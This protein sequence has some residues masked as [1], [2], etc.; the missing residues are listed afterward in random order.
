MNA[1]VKNTSPSD[2]LATMQGI[3]S[4]IENHTTRNAYSKA[5]EVKR[6][7]RATIERHRAAE[8]ESSEENHKPH[9]Q[10]RREL[11]RLEQVERWI[12][13]VEAEIPPVDW[14]GGSIVSVHEGLKIIIDRLADRARAE[15]KEATAQIKELQS[16]LSQ[17]E[18]RTTDEGA[19]LLKWSLVDLGAM[20]AYRYEFNNVINAY[21]C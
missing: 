16:D 15:I 8:P 7:T 21:D 17:G 20:Q 12:E 6:I 2:L 10:W 4:T 11:N 13:L 19:D 9:T 3:V 14:C 5:G 18:Y 1:T